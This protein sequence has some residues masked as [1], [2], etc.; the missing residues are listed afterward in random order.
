MKYEY[1]TFIKGTQ[2]NH[3]FIC[4]THN[5]LIESAFYHVLDLFKKNHFVGG[6]SAIGNGELRLTYKVE[7]GKNDIYLEYLKN[8]KKKIKEY[9]S[10]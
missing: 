2:F 1:E 5:A 7:L 4:A 3:Q 10:T 9:F 6:M 8:N